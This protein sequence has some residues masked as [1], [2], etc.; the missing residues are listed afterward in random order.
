MAKILEE[1]KELMEQEDTQEDVV[2]EEEVPEI[3][4]EEAEEAEEAEEE[5]PE[6]EEKEEAPIAEKKE[7]EEKETNLS[8]NEDIRV[9][10][11]EY[12]AMRRKA[13]KAENVKEQEADPESY[14]KQLM[15]EAL[16]DIKIKKA[17]REFQVMEG[18]FLRSSGIKDYEDVTNGYRNSVYNSLRILNPRVSHE[19]LIDMTRKQILIKASEYLNQ[20]LD[21][22]AEMYFQARELGFKP[23]KKEEPQVN[24]EKKPKTALKKIAQ[25]KKRSSGMA[26]APSSGATAPS[27]DLTPKEFKE[28]S[29]EQK[30]AYLAEI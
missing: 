19:D 13:Q 5:E 30:R 20:G 18:D 10:K 17:A 11:N 12:Y 27:S 21:P 2:Q 26:G 8:D 25:N 24:E 23:A 29:P 16:Q 6:E 22:I 28:L 7:V 1:L 3:V 14:E 4:E 9:K 15:Q